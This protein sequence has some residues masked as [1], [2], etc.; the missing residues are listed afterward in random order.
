M[1]LTTEATSRGR[2]AARR[3]LAFD[4]I[5]APA[6]VLD[7]GGVV[8]ETNQAWRLHGRLHD[9]VPGETAVG[10]D[11]LALFDRAAREGRPDAAAAAAAVRSVLAGERQAVEV[12]VARPSAHEDRWTLL[13]VTATPVG[14]ALGA[15]V[16]H[17]DVTGRRLLADRLT[18]VEG[19]DPGTGLPDASAVTEVLEAA[20]I[21]AAATGRSLTVVGV[22]VDGVGAVAQQ[23]GPGAG[24]D[25]TTQLVARLR[26]LVRRDDALLRRDDHRLLVVTTDAEPGTADS[27][28]VRFRTSLT[29]PLQVGAAEVT[30]AAVVGVA[31]CD[32][33][34]EVD[35][36]L[37][38]CD[39]AVAEAR[40]AEGAVDPIFGL[41]FR[42]PD[43][44]PPRA[45]IETLGPDDSAQRA[46]PA[47]APGAA[48][49]R[50]EEALRSVLVPDGRRLHEWLDAEIDRTGGALALLLVSVDDAHDVGLALGHPAAD[51]LVEACGAALV[52]AA[53][54]GDVVARVAGDSLAV[55]SPRLSDPDEALAHAEHLRRALAE[56]L[57]VAGAHIEVRSSVGVALAEGPD[58]AAPALLERADTALF[59][60]REAGRDSVALYDDAL[61]R[62][63]ARQ[64]EV[65]AVLRAAIERA[66][67]PMAY[68]PI[69]RL[70]DQAMWGAE[71]LLRLC[72]ERGD[73]IPATE[74]VRVA[75]RTGAIAELGRLVLRQTCADAARWVRARPDRQFVVTVNISSRQLGD[76]ALPDVV[77]DELD[78]AGLQ[79]SRLVLEISESALM[80]DPVRAAR[81]LAQ[82][83]MRGVRLLVDD[84]GTGRSSLANLKRFP[85]D[86][87]KLDRSFISG[88]PS[89]P[90]DHAIVRAMVGVAQALGLDAVAEGVEDE[91]QLAELQR[92][93]CGY[94]QG[95]LWSRAVRAD[96]VPVLLATRAGHAEDAEDA[97]GG[98]DDADDAGREDGGAAGEPEPAAVEAAAPEVV[99]PDATSSVDSA[100]RVLVHEIRTPLTVVMGY[101]SL[102][103]QVEDPDD[104]DAAA[105]IRRASERIE[106][107]IRNLDDV[108]SV[109]NGTL[110][111]NRRDVEVVP[112]VERVVDDVRDA[113]N[114]PLVVQVEGTPRSVAFDDVRIE[115]TLVNLVTNAAKYTPMGLTIV[116][117]ARF[118]EEW[119]DIS[120]LDEG[121]G[122][123][124]EELGLIFRKYG[125]AERSVPGTGLGLYLARGIARAHGGDVLYRRRQPEPGSVFTLR[126]PAG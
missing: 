84:F 73:P 115:Q 125:R 15:V 68:Q 39:A 56:P 18:A 93:G 54:P 38:A 33:T 112:F 51:E 42:G 107:L 81:R 86:G 98:P 76:P 95:Y 105:R 21:R 75:E 63:L 94:G 49:D 58:D 88:L 64:L 122:I 120:V 59:R 31:T 114:A 57:Q 72:D 121:P 12:E 108:G 79:P 78:A 116:V 44:R 50:D 60:A 62:R 123:P 22:E 71:A 100:F 80:D 25:V 61:R 117:E 26:R 96:A 77:A 101:A 30:L 6:A 19:I 8:V 66:E 53:R 1:A 32:P 113:L 16:C 119:L 10:V 70:G 46:D 47:P 36:V 34:A 87:I 45:V 23:L 24:A 118:G 85:I 5:A 37:A 91:Q 111:L 13:Q 103:E 97:E 92:L 27:V 126:L 99:A 90:E 4:R 29:V 83:K 74:V 89:S 9:I 35:A 41:S 106:R 52:A 67:V 28:A 55:C 7:G 109:D 43:G 14:D 102:L 11:Y 2:S 17:L 48:D 69:M 110:R 20:R 82:L 104:A 40:A 65:E 3:S 124:N